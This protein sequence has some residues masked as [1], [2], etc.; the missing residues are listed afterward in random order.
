MFLPGGCSSALSQLNR[1]GATGA[2]HNEVFTIYSQSLGL[3]SSFPVSPG[4]N[5]YLFMNT[6]GSEEYNSISR[7]Q[8]L[9]IICR[10]FSI[11]IL[12]AFGSRAQEACFWLSE[13]AE[14]MDQ[15]SSDLDIGVLP[16]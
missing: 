9:A 2:L 1:L 16:I 10:E 8:N 13:E 4:L 11:A 5:R 6:P 7:R 14:V 3:K 12:Y 15:S